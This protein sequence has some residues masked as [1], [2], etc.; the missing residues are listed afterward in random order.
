[1][2]RQILTVLGLSSPEQVPLDR[3]ID[4]LWVDPPTS[5]AKT[6]QAQV[7]RL[8]R[9]LAEAGGSGSLVGGGS[10]Y[11]L[12]LGD[13]IDTYALAQLTA[14]AGA[15]REGGDARLA[16]ELF[17]QARELWRGEPELPDTYSG[18]A[19]RR[20]LHD[21]RLELAVAHSAALVDAHDGARKPID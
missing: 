5:A 9:A 16:A 20:R 13:R 2:A 12:D 21:Q 15:A 6:V 10:G 7:G 4:L 8:R 11:Q 17:G 19:L 14:R 18:D 3:L 1:M